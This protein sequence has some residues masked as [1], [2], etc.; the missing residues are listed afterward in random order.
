[1]RLTTVSQMTLPEGV[2]RSLEMR[3][4]VLEDAVLP[5]SFDQRRHVGAGDRPG[6]WM[7][8]AFRLPEQAARSEIAEAWAAAVTRHAALRTVFD[9]D[10]AGELRLREARVEVAGWRL[11]DDAVGA[12]P[13]EVLAGLFDARCRPFAAPSHLLCL[14]EPHDA[15]ADPDPRPIAVIASDHSHV[16]MWSLLVLARDLEAGIQD[17]HDGRGPE[18]APAPA[19][20]DHTR[21]LAAQPPAPAAVAARWA[22]VLDAGGGAMPRFPLPLG[23]PARTARAVVGVDDI[24]DADGLAALTARAA[25]SGVR[26]TALAMSALADATLALS[27]APLRAVFPVHSRHGGRWDDAVGWFIT[28]SVLELGDPDPHACAAALRDAI[29]LGSYPL[30]PLLAPYGGMVEPHGM[31][32]LSWLDTRRM[33]VGVDAGF[34]VQYVSATVSTDGVMVWFIV[35]DDGLH[36][37]W[38]HP[39]TQAARTNVRAWVDAV[40]DRLG[41]LRPG[42]PAPASAP[43]ALRGGTTG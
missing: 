25:R 34:D 43:I 28:N 21:L 11:H 17:L 12:H 8:I 23:D 32:A 6:S 13:R 19:F 38:R 37:R 9:R 10:A 26:V 22:E 30:A 24:L 31:F 15:S 20:A 40:A 41:G 7:A 35:N 1:M 27:G 14:V 29:R 16:D 42:G 4:D 39:D 3:A 5:I 18:T 36:V 33:P 2:V